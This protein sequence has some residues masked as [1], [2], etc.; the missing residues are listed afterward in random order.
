MRHRLP[1]P[2][3]RFRLPAVLL[4]LVLVY[5]IT[6][7]TLIERWSLLDAFYMTIITISTVGYSE[8][9]GLSTAGR[10][11]TST[12]IVVGVGTMLYGFGVFAETLTDNSFVAYRRERQLERALNH[13][14]DHFIICGYGRIGTQIVA[15]FED[16]NAPYAVID[17]TEEALIR[18]RNEDRLHVEGDASS[19]EILKLAGIERA[20]G[21]ISAV[22]SDERSVY[23]TLAARALRPEL[24]I[25]SRAGRPESIRRLELAGANRVISPYRMAGH[26]M[27]ELALRPALV[28]V[29]D[30][31]HHG[32]S[33]IAVEEMLV[34][35]GMAAVG[36]S[37]AEVGLMSADAAKL[38]AVRRTDGTVHI[39]PGPDLRLEEGD[40][41]I[42]L[43]SEDQLFASAAL[44]K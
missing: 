35:P 24:Y 42:A 9:H 17:Q 20:R 25:L 29:L 15:E 30:T 4:L 27:A 19:E 36:N 7:Y 1:H 2:L 23:I 41:L 5:G 26:R 38:L 44:L 40:L 39:N 12:L 31:L 18:L 22:D 33:E 11:F 13:L 43:G 34:K 21:L 8:L 28:D 32:M 6:G 14:R 16:H 37:V 3:R 10:L